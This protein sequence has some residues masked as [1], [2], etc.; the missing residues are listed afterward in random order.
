MSDDR[1]RGRLRHG[2]S[3]ASIV[4]PPGWQVVDDVGA[5][6]CEGPVARADVTGRAVAARLSIETV[7]RHGLVAH[8]S[9]DAVV[10][11]LVAD[12]RADDPHAWL[13]DCVPWA[14]R[15]A[16][17]AVDGIRVDVAHH[18][19]STPLVVST[20]LVSLGSGLLRVTAS[21]PVAHQQ[22]LGADVDAALG[23]LTAPAQ[24]VP[25]SGTVE[26]QPP[27][28][29]SPRATARA[30]AELPLAYVLP[31][32]WIA[33]DVLD[34]FITGSYKIAARWRPEPLAAGLVDERGVA[35]PLGGYVRRAVSRPDAR[36]A[37]TV[38]PVETVQHVGPR[39]GSGALAVMTIDRLDGWAVVRA[40][41][42]PLQSVMYGSAEHGHGHVSLEVVDFAA[43]PARAAAWLGTGPGRAARL[44]E[45]TLAVL[46]TARSGAPGA[47]AEHAGSI[48][49]ALP[50]PRDVWAR[51][52]DAVG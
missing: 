44:P 33:A 6:A 41:L 46:G 10:R 7:E 30:M 34:V 9:L 35:T 45:G 24:P 17:G 1:S 50:G 8:R 13:L 27:D 37:L 18:D 19:V 20:V 39:G 25:G 48:V 47:R 11:D 51:L 23:S 28:T 4:V 14:S 38:W 15:N 31:R 43:A 36:A 26:P 2:A 21:V 22:A 16:E 40:T 52:L 42:P 49:S 3:G 29:A 12:A 32:T 5:V